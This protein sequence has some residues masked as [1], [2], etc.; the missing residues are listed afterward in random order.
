[1]DHFVMDMFAELVR[2]GVIAEDV[3][4]RMAD[5][6]DT[7]DNSIIRAK[8]R[9]AQ[10]VLISAMCEGGMSRREYEADFRRRQMVERTALYE[11]QRREAEQPDGGNESD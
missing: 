9:I 11:R 4:V 8:G 10:G 3:L 2:K 1:M 6:D 7:R 5:T